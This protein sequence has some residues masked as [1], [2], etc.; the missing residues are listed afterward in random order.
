[1][2]EEANGIPE[3][4]KCSE[5]S[6]KWTRVFLVCTTGM[7]PEDTRPQGER[8]W[9]VW[10]TRAMEQ[11]IHDASSALLGWVFRGCRNVRGGRIG[12]RNSTCQ[13]LSVKDIAR[14]S[15]NKWKWYNVSIFW[16]YK[17]AYDIT[18]LSVCVPFF[19]LWIRCPIFTKHCINFTPLEAIQTS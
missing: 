16:V 2:E 14:W 1:M 4:N 9:V 7:R 15:S 11:P 13:G 6:V 19:N 12:V 10:R 8:S 5:T 18:E 17:S 3:W